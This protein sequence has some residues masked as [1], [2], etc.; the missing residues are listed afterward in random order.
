MSAL[1]RLEVR[2]TKLESG[3]IYTGLGLVHEAKGGRPH[4]AA[5][6]ILLLMVTAAMFLA[7]CG[8]PATLNELPLPVVTVSPVSATVQ[9][10]S[11]LQFQVT[12][13]SPT[14][15]TI[16]WAVNDI[17]GGNSTVGTVTASGLYTAPAAIPNPATVTV[18][19]ISSAETNPFG[20]AIVTVTP[21]AAGEGVSVSPTDT[22][23][24]VGTSVQY[25]ATVTGFDNTAVTWSVDGVAGGNSTVGT[26][27]ASG[28]YQSPTALPN[29]ATVAISATSQADSSQ[30][31]STILTLTSNN[32]V[33]LYVNSGLN[34]NPG[35]AGTAAYNG[36]FTTISVCLPSTPQCQIIPNIL[37]DT[38]T[39][40]LRLLNSALT[41]VPSTE[42]KTVT[43]STGNQVQ[44]CVQFP[45]TSYTWGPVLIADVA[46]SGEKAAGVP[47]QILGDTTFPVPLADCLS[48]GTGP[49]LNS[50]AALGA[51]GILGVGTSVQDCGLNCAAGQTFSAYP[52]YVCPLN[53]CQPVPLPVAQQVANPVAFFPKDNNGVLI[54]LPSIPDAGAPTLPFANPD[55]SGLIP[56]GQLVF[57]VGTEPN[58]ALGSAMLY[59]LDTNDNFAQV[60]Y[61][62]TTYDSGGSI[63]SSSNAL[64]LA[65]PAILGI[66]N[67]LDNPFYCPG[68]TT[69]VSLT[70]TGANGASGTVTVNVANADILFSDNP[71]FSAF[72]N[73]A[74]ESV[75]SSASDQFV[76]GLPFFFGRTVF[77]GIAG[78]TIPNNVSAPNGYVAF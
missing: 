8:T 52:Y 54:S 50:V 68:S 33:P 20:A 65:S 35:N 9:A 11:P 75:N 6:A 2:G 3:K 31:D 53:V 32:S 72:N 17:Q 37:V 5:W 77:V 44:E 58:N 13:V 4:A 14:A 41:T 46:I 1:P 26:I 60:V 21:P 70:T 25:T 61:N 23:A 78:T 69:P 49:E 71:D 57:G 43:D 15:T 74:R 38:S 12:I 42:L 67:C 63:D 56:A 40:G 45:D 48:L 29:P 34:G 47:I 18:K 30:S 39:V 36:L 27:S 7:G 73:L 16:T 10:G 59:T 22:L 19:A 62:G 28:L 64:L 24:P 76:L 51:N 66:Q 55:G